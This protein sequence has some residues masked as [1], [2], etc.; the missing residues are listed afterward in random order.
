[1]IV[2]GSADD[3]VCSL[4]FNSL[5]RILSRRNVALFERCAIRTVTFTC[6]RAASCRAARPLCFPTIGIGIV[7]KHAHYFKS[8]I[9]KSE[10]LFVSAAG[11]A[12]CPCTVNAIGAKS[13]S[14]LSF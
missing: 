5:D 9:F 13:S 8:G 2:S 12:I 7:L 4:N 11:F 6:C 3:D 1:V 14:E 10:A